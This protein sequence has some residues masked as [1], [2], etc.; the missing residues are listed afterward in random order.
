MTLETPRHRYQQVADHIRAAISSGEYEPGSKLPSQPTL[1]ERFGITQR[2][3]GA[4]I[5]VLR[6]EGLVRVV[7]NVGAFVR[8]LPPLPRHA[9]TRYTKASRETGNARGA[10]DS[11]LRGQGH[12]TKTEIVQLGQVPATKEAAEALRLTEGAPVAIRKRHMSTGTTP[13][14]VATSY[15]PWALAEGTAILEEDT[16]KGGTYSRLTE[17]GHAPTRFTEAVKTRTATPEE[18]EF[19]NVDPEQQ[20]F[21]ILHTA[22]DARD[23]PVEV[24][25]H[26][27]P[28]F[29][30]E[31][32]YEWP[33]G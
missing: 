13:V 8:E 22:W 30:W 16:G 9:A 6:R 23:Q 25:F 7:D 11:E 1:A 29:Q 28:T 19:L 33:A 31:L 21:A 20:V 12:E 17:Q 4:A 14:Q 18:A 15:I 10:F 32:H 2:T 5:A 3:A 26:V 24:C 27:M